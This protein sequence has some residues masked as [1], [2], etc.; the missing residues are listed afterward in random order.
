MSNNNEYIIL[1]LYFYFFFLYLQDIC[2]EKEKPNFK[3]YL[4]GTLL[5]KDHLLLITR[6]NN[7][8][9]FIIYKVPFNNIEGS[10]GLLLHNITGTPLEQYWPIFQ[11]NSDWLERRQK[12]FAIWLINI[13]RPYL[14]L[15]APRGNSFC[16]DIEKS[17]YCSVIGA[18]SQTGIQFIWDGST[19]PT[20][21]NSEAASVFYW[22][23]YEVRVFN[24]GQFKSLKHYPLSSCHMYYTRSRLDPTFRNIT[25]IYG[26]YK[27]IITPE[28]DPYNRIL[29][30][31]NINDTQQQNEY[32]ITNLTDWTQNRTFQPPGFVF[33][34]HFFIFDPNY[35]F[36]FANHLSMEN[37]NIKNPNIKQGDILYSTKVSAIPVKDYF[38]CDKLAHQSST[39]SSLT[40]SRYSKTS[41]SSSTGNDIGFDWWIWIL[42]IVFV[43][44]LLIIGCFFIYFCQN[45]GKNKKKM[46]NDQ[47]SSSD[48]H[49]EKNNKE[50]LKKKMHKNETKNTKISKVRSSKM[51]KILPK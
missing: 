34:D 48:H 7:G 25:F 17:Q 22:N 16:F 30:G 13:V 26:S 39:N 47:T 4:L 38:L 36:I 42:I 51:K 46:R 9:E 19:N 5:F 1:F 21:S 14:Y 24:N 35:V 43:I 23:L 3:L 32:Y 10:Y 45:S 18:Y 20:F 40:T 44:I 15:Y 28:N 6:S 50:N 49:K 31:V 33:R 12:V 27:Y 11:N 37:P 2:V 29:M 41:S 8:E